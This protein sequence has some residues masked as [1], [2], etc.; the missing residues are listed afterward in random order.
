MISINV[1]SKLQ[2]FI[3]QLST[4]SEGLDLLEQIYMELGPYT[5]VLS[6]P[7]VTRLHKFFKFDDSE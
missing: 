6:S 4:V 5:N 2:D 7:L 1:D 3:E